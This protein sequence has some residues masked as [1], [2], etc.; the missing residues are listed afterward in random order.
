[1]SQSISNRTSN[2]AFITTDTSKIFLRDKRFEQGT[3]DYTNSTYDD[4]T[5]Y[6]GTLLGRIAATNKL[7]VLTSAA[8]NGSQFP[9]GIL[10]Q[11]I[12]VEAG[13]SYSDTVNMCVAGDVAVERLIFQGSDTLNT[14]VSTR[15]LRDRIGADTV[16]VKLVSATELT[17]YDNL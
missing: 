3:F 14:V 16:G 4:V 17:E 8:S 5:I 13:D 11:D 7:V 12:T 6:A 9:V 10:A 1:M 15:T 2:Q